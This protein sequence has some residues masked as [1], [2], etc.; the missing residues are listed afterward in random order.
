[1]ISEKFK[2]TLNETLMDFE[3]KNLMFSKDSKRQHL[4]PTVAKMIYLLVQDKI[5]EG[6]DLDVPKQAIYLVCCCEN[7]F[8]KKYISRSHFYRTLKKKSS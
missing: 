1:M 6:L 8:F 7:R 4:Q 2:K 5:Q 3:N